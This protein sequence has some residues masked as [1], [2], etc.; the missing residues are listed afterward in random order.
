MGSQ[1]AWDDAFPA[2]IRKDEC[3]Y[4]MYSAG[5]IN[6]F[7]EK[8]IQA[9]KCKKGLLRQMTGERASRSQEN[10]AI[11]T[12]VENDRLAINLEWVQNQGRR[13]VI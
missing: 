7:Q 8:E 11:K 2:Q 10:S 12:Q 5:L 1:M 4:A 9:N 13:K 6:Y 3:H